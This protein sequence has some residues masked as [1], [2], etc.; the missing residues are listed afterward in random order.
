VLLFAP[1][2][3]VTKAPV[4]RPMVAPLDLVRA[5]L[6]PSMSVAPPPP[7]AWNVGATPAPFDVKI[8]PAVPTAVAPIAPVPLP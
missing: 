2:L 5:S 7:A 8:C 4:P 1:P 3:S 6:R